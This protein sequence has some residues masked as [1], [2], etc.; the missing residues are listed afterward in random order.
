M[1]QI[2]PFEQGDAND[3]SA[4]HRRVF[5]QEATPTPEFLVETFLRNPSFNPEVA[6][7]VYAD[8]SDK[9][10]G[11]VGVVPRTVV[12][13]NITGQAAIV[14]YLMVSPDSRSSM[15]A[16][17]LLKHLFAGPQVLSVAGAANQAGRAVWTAMGAEH[18]PLYGFHWQRKLRA[19][20]CRR[21]AGGLA[22]R[23]AA[24]ELSESTLSQVDRVDRIIGR[25]YRRSEDWDSLSLLPRAVKT[26][27]IVE[28]SGK[29]LWRPTTFTYTPDSL[30][31]LLQRAKPD[32]ED[33]SE[34]HV[35]GVFD[36][37]DK[38]VGLFAYFVD[39]RRMARVVHLGCARGR[40][41]DVFRALLHDAWSKDAIGV[42]GRVDPHFADSI[43]PTQSLEYRRSSVGVVVHSKNSS[44]LSSLRS[45]T[46]ALSLLE[47]EWGIKYRTRQPSPGP[48]PTRP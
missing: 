29:S 5:T 39:E 8:G 27:D 9:I 43:A 14:C 7:L 21:I 16:M 10:A 13:K 30:Q 23:A 19:T 17:L 11:F 28:V 34:L 24:R 46:L 37:G 31:W 4:L 33:D 48:A 2:R 20:P 45:G 6:A 40:H 47:D 26:G 1:G 41:E 12:L 35:K 32:H 15:A 36:A 42:G 3:V 18:L 22:R 44:I 25:A 38:L